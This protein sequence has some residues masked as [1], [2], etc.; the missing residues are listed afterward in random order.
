MLIGT[1]VDDQEHCLML[2]D[3]LHVP[4]A[5]HGLFSPG[6]AIEHGL[7]I[8]LSTNMEF[9]VSRRGTALVKAVFSDGM[10]G[11]SSSNMQATKTIEDAI[12]SSHHDVT[13]GDVDVH[14]PA[15]F[16]LVNFSV[17]AG[18]APMKQWHE[19][20]GHTCDQYLKIMA[21]QGLVDG[22]VVTA[23]HTT[24]CDACHIGK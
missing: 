13:A 12:S 24:T 1:K 10:W 7:D 2:D 22:M 18:Q 5:K 23:R 19:R 17:A 14:T 11:F 8:S 20:L 15:Q 9:V 21:D 4:D 16:G 6:K 3:V